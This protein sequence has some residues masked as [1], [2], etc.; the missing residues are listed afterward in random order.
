M[1]CKAEHNAVPRRLASETS[2]KA[3]KYKLLAEMFG[4]PHNCGVG[5]PGKHQAN[6][7]RAVGNAA[8][9]AATKKDLGLIL[10]VPMPD[11]ML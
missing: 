6:H 9:E 8:W 2:E 7:A 1:P 4:F 10:E 5:H 3:L 11:V